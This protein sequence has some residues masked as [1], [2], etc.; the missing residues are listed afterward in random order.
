MST[1]D[2]FILAII[3]GLTEF[4]P[5]SSSAHLILPSAVFGWQDQGQA[6]DVALHVG[7]LLAV[8]LYFRKEVGSMTVAWFGTVGVGPEKKYNSFDGKLAWWIILASIPLGIVG[9]LGKDFIEANLR[10]AAVIAITTLVFGILLGFADIKAKENVSVEKLGFKGAMIIGLAQVL[11]L[12][13]GTSRSG[14]TMT[15]GLMLGLNKENAARFSFLLSIPAIV[16]SGGYL[17]YKLISSAEPV[18]WSTLGLG[19]ILAF[20]SAY[21]CIHYFL[22]LVSKVGMMPFVIYRLILGAGLL[23]FVLG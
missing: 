22:I 2:V 13:P 6:L 7:T 10:S 20:F 23:W 9:L 11:A 17:T 1:I 5:I 4:L 16:M 19:S 14:I 3:Q 18:D 12:I 8:V 15:L 21:A